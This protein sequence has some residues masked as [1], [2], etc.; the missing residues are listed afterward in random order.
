MTSGTLLLECEMS[1]TDFRVYGLQLMVMFGEVVIPIWGGGGGGK[2]QCRWAFRFY[3]L[4]LLPACPLLPDY[5]S[6]GPYYQA[7]PHG[8]FRLEQHAL[9]NS[10]GQILY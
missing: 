2:S 7:F 5:Q 10:L 3:S 1:P 9:E 4:A 8:R 6:R